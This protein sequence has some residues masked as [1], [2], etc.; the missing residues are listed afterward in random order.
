MNTNVIYVGSGGAVPMRRQGRMIFA[1]DATGSRAGT[2]D[3]AKKAQADMFIK[4]APYGTLA[5]KLAFYRGS[6]NTSQCAFSNWVASGDELARLMN[7]IECCGGFTQIGSVLRQTLDEHDKAPIQSLTFI[8]DCCEEPMDVLAGLAGR[9]GNAG[10]PIFVFQE[11]DDPEAREIFMAMAK[12]S[13]GAYFKFNPAKV[14]MI[15]K[16]FAAVACH[17]VGDQEALTALT[18]Q[19]RKP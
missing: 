16:Q 6:G 15:A 4:A 1:V 14:D 9:L 3:I 19:R 12:A 7:K 8:G 2:W 17:A 13:G 10:V 11:G 5:V 18:D